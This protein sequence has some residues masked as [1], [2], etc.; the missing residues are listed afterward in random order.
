MK[1]TSMA[2]TMIMHVEDAEQFATNVA[3]ALDNLNLSEDSN[4]ENPAAEM[5]SDTEDYDCSPCSP[6]H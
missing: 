3:S 1:T 5:D 2:L 6:S 4:P